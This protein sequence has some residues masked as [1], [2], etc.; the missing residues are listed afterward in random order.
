MKSQTSSIGFLFADVAPYMPKSVARVLLGLSWAQLMAL[1]T[2]PICFGKNIIN[3]VQLWKASKILVGVDLA[4]RAMERSI[5]KE[6]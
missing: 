6:E 1:M 2:F 5:I 4:N 3:M